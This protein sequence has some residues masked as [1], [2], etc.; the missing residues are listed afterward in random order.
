MNAVATLLYSDDYLPGALVLAHRMRKLVDNNTKLVVLIDKTNF[1]PFQIDL[2]KK[3]YDEL[4][5]VEVF[6]LDLHEQLADLKRPELAETFT[7]IHLWALK[8]SKVLYLDADTL[9]IIEGKGSVA[10][11]LRLDF[12]KGKILAAPDSGFPD[13][14]NSGVFVLR[15]ERNDYNNLLELVVSKDSS[16]SFDGADQGLLNQYFNSEP[17]W[18]S[19][20]LSSGLTEVDDAALVRTNWISIPFMYNTTPTAQYEYLPAF[21][22]FEP[23][24]L[25]LDEGPSS[26]SRAMG[27]PDASDEVSSVQQTLWTYH[28][29][30]FNHFGNRSLVKLIHFIGP[31]K[32]WNGS[33]AG[34]FEK[35]WAAW[36]DYSNG[37]LIKDTLFLQHYTV[38]VKSLIIPEQVVSVA[39]TA[40]A[41]AGAPS[42]FNPQRYYPPEE[43]CNPDNYQYAASDTAPGW[44]AT[45]EEPP[46]EAPHYS[47]FEHDM[48]S[49][50]NQWD[51]PLW[52]E[53]EPSFEPIDGDV[54]ADTVAVSEKEEHPSTV[55][56]DFESH[57][58]YGYHKLQRAERVFDDRSDYI[59]Q[60]ALLLRHAEQV[61]KKQGAEDVSDLIRKLDV[62]DTFADELE[63]EA[64]LDDEEDQTLEAAAVNFQHELDS[65][66]PKLFPW[67]FRDGKGPER[68]FD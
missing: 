46:S 53:G 6:R 4:I 14:F 50:S 13:I 51:E 34:L 11:L 65:D 25:N 28:Q 56:G 36:Y 33:H 17:D 41:S 12:P 59:P 29:A 54:D 19:R 21:K 5:S 3:S 30:S 58:E 45:R 57:Y 63:T 60:H 44:D 55:N 24:G 49:F 37:R 31:L 67:E 27:G 8:Y 61:S 18:T 20:L 32:P 38:S 23:F 40:V 64:D 66:V 52:E 26:P 16:I 9:P 7:K 42:A 68:S 47:D 10:D 62:A 15:P 43:L 39:P 48:K 22:H 2:L 1:S 35:W